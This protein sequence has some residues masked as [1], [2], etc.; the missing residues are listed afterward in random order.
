[1]QIKKCNQTSCFWR[2]KERNGKRARA[3]GREEEEEE[4]EE[5]GGAACRTAVGFGTFGF[6]IS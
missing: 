1:L 2:S 6:G 3:G 5:D 4:E